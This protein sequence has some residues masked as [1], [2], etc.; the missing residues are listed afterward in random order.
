[1]VDR[2]RKNLPPAYA[3]SANDGATVAKRERR[4]QP[5]AIRDASGLSGQL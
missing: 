4:C 1:M 2:T 3:F 5:E